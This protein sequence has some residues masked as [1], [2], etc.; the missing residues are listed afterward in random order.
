M[1]IQTDTITIHLQLHLLTNDNYRIQHHKIQE[2]IA[3]LQYFLKKIKRV[4]FVHFLVKKG[5][6][7]PGWFLSGWFLSGWFLSGV[8]F[9]LHPEDCTRDFLKPAKQ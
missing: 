8:V 7:C 5:G 6:L 9:V 3:A 1:Y 2:N 4:V